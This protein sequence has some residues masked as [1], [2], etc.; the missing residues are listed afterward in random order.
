MNRE[1][2]EKKKKEK[3][4]EEEEKKNIEAWF[5]DLNKI[6][7]DSFISYQQ[8]SVIDK[9][10]REKKILLKEGF[11]T[12]FEY[13]QWFML[14]IQLA[15][16]FSKKQ[17]QEQKQEQTQKRN[18]ITLFDEIIKEEFSEQIKKLLIT[19]DHESI[20]INDEKSAFDDFKALSACDISFEDFITSI[21]GYRKVKTCEEFIEHI[22]ELKEDFFFEEEAF[23]EKASTKAAYQKV[24]KAIEEIVITRNKA[25]AHTDIGNV[26]ITSA[27][28]F[29]IIEGI[30]MLICIA[31]EKAI[32]KKIEEI[33][34]NVYAYFDIGRAT[35][36]TTENLE[37][38]EEIKMCVCYEIGKAIGEVVTIR[39]KVYAHNGIDRATIT[40]I[41][42]LPTIEEIKIFIRATIGKAIKKVV[43]VRDKVYAHTDIYSE[44]AAVTAPT[45][46]ELEM[47][48]K[49][50]SYL[51]N[52]SRGALYDTHT[53]FTKTMN[54]LT[55]DWIIKAIDERGKDK[56]TLQEK[57]KIIEKLSRE[58]EEDRKA[59]QEKDKTIE[60]PKRGLE[61]K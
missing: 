48:I 8:L 4:K 17:K 60:E 51:Y 9:K 28:D 14:I 43:E 6:I 7:A 10:R 24:Q 5:N 13:Q 22:K 41:E 38:I 19:R 31:I 12:F 27:K 1:K 11:F 36:T 49:A 61:E 58:R 56:E 55:I 35:I 26:A 25:Y 57:N 59:L 45:M 2:K 33:V 46:G 47:L 37:T 44:R 50:A 54:G 18:I 16:I 32:E 30:K 23:L 3:K 42:N 40:T 21:K 34:I 39:D 52:Q 53:D 29:P 15:K 20:I